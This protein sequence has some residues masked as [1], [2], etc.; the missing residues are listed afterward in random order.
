MDPKPY[1]IVEGKYYPVNRTGQSNSTDEF[2]GSYWRTWREQE[3]CFLEYDE[4][5]FATKMRTIEI[6]DIQYRG[7][8]DG[9][10]TLEKV[11]RAE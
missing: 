9:S 7:L 6:S 4:G 5:H 10:T 2:I 11:V 8:V 3:R 1:R